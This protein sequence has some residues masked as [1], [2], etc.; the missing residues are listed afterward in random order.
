[1]IQGASNW[2]PHKLMFKLQDATVLSNDKTKMI[3]LKTSLNVMKAAELTIYKEKKKLK[4][5]L[6]W[7]HQYLVED[8]SKRN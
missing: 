8:S 5:L 1:M 3:K 2:F 4:C 7:F 6:K